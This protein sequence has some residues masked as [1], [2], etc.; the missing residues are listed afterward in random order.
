MIINFRG[1]DIF[2]NIGYNA[3]LKILLQMLS[4][5]KPA[6][7]PPAAAAAKDQKKKKKIPKLEDLLDNRDYTG[8]I[9]LLEVMTKMRSIIS[10]RYSS[11]GFHLR[12]SCYA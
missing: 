10:S 11:N 5:T 3:F 4:R 6:N 12:Y 9:T 7:A 2:L 1:V 8:A